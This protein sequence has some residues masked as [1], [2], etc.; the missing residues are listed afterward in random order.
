MQVTVA[1][2]EGVGTR[3]SYYEK[4]GALRD[5]VQNHILQ[6]LCL[7]AVEPPWAITADVVRDHKL[8]V[9]NCLRPISVSEVD[10]AQYG[11]VFTTDLRCRAI[12]TKMVLD[13]I[14]LLRLTCH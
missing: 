3:A 1:D 11:W 12:A 10:M 9:L 2:E 5:M 6:L 4:A 7:T 14:E 13:R 8:E